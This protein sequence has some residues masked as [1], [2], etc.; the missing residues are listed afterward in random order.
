M[1]AFFWETYRNV[2]VFKDELHFLYT[3]KNEERLSRREK[4]RQ[5]IITEYIYW[6]E[7]ANAQSKKKMNEREMERKRR[8]EEE[9][10]GRERMRHFEHERL[11]A[12]IFKKDP[13]HE[14]GK[15]ILIADSTVV[16][17]SA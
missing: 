10:R 13:Q 12:C 7:I 16:F 17:M 1:N 6:L 15:K 2:S 9:N 11:I 8:R 5:R 3:H 14:K 4:E